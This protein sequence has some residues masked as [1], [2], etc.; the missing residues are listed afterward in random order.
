[1]NKILTNAVEDAKK[2][3]TEDE[4]KS[5]DGIENALRAYADE[6]ESFEN[7]VFEIGLKKL[8]KHL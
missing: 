4:M 5:K 7:M 6:C 8:M 3:L 1:M 2:W